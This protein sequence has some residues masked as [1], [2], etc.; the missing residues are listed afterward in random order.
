MEKERQFSRIKFSSDSIIKF[1]GMT[2]EVHLK[3]LSLKGALLEHQSDS[4]FKMGSKC[5]LIISLSASEIKLTFE[6]EILHL[7]EKEIGLKFLGM[8]IDTMTHLR[9]LIDMNSDDDVT[10]NEIAHWLK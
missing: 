10:G 2:F 7:H 1:S 5:E 8:D 4:I 9:R 3:N 6:A